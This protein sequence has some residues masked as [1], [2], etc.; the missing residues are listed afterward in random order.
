VAAIR[1]LIFNMVGYS[2]LTDCRIGSDCLER[3]PIYSELVS[4][5]CG[6]QAC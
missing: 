1:D 4:L 5:T 2:L 6:A 3:A